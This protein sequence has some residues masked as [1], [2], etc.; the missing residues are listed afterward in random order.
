MLQCIRSIFRRSIQIRF[1]PRVAYHGQPLY[2]RNF[3]F[4]FSQ[5]EYI[6][7]MLSQYTFQENGT[8]QYIDDGEY[9]QPGMGNGAEV[10]YTN[11][12]VIIIISS[13]TRRSIWQH[14][15][16]FSSENA[17]RIRCSM[18]ATNATLCIVSCE[19]T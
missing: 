19:L 13:Q 2:L 5:S 4:Y 7:N 17:R 15:R 6:L 16:S 1:R 3:T 14:N 10:V 9:D 11:V 18:S 8:E 12:S